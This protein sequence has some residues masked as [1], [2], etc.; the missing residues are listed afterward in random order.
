MSAYTQVMPL[1]ME[2]GLRDNG[3]RFVETRFLEA[4]PF[5]TPTEKN[6]DLAALL[7]KSQAGDHEAMEKIYELYRRSL[8]NLAYRHTYNLAV[9]EDLLQDIFIK[10]FTN[11][12]N[13]QDEKTFA[14]WMYRIAVN[15]CYSFLRDRKGRASRTIALSSVEGRKEEAVYDR[16]EESLK[17]PLDEA[18][19]RLPSRLKTVFLLHD[20]QGFKHEEIAGM[21]GLTVGTSKSQ[22]FKARLKIRAF[23]KGKDYFRED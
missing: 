4:L 6:T 20:V 8:F 23:L 2:I 15:T 3:R 10:I 11:L 9:A 19:E 7:K 21:L 14:A 17:K 12:G 16:H 13:V 18:I 5:M 1:A 22:L